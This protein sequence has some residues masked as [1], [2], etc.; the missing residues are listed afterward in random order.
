VEPESA[1]ALQRRMTAPDFVHA[2]N[3]LGKTVRVIEVARLDLILLGVEVLLAP[4]L[5]RHVLGEL[6]PAVDAV[7]GAERRRQD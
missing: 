7:A 2:P 5:E 6:E 4:G 3:Q 1:V